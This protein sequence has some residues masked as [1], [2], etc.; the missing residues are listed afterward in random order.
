M[1]TVAFAHDLVDM[2]ILQEDDRL[3]VYR[4][5]ECLPACLVSIQSRAVYDIAIKYGTEELG[6]DL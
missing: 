3:R 5:K 6:I 1:E 4:T 2:Y